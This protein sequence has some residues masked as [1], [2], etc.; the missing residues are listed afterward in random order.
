MVTL[1][2]FF[3]FLDLPD[4]VLTIVCYCTSEIALLNYY[5]ETINYYYLVL[6]YTTFSSLT[7]SLTANVHQMEDHWAYCH[8]VSQAG[9]KRETGRVTEK[10]RS[11]QTLATSHTDDQFIVTSATQNWLINAKQL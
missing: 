2:L 7:K 3:Y 9:C 5:F 10:L 8:R 4:N 6:L 11:G 1:K